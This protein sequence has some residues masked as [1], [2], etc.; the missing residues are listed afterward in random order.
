MGKY[1]ILSLFFLDLL[2]F[3]SIVSDTV[4]LLESYLVR[5]VRRFE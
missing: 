5:L 2:V 3:K 1:E 4:Y